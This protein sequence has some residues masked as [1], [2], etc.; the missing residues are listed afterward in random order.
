[1]HCEDRAE[2]NR[3]RQERC[4][5]SPDSEDHPD[6]I[7]SVDR[8]C[9]IELLPV[10]LL[11]RR[12]RGDL[13][14]EL[15]SG[16]V[17]PVHRALRN[18]HFKAPPLLFGKTKGSAPFRLSLHV[19]DVGH[20]LVDGLTGAGKSVLLALMALQFRRCPEAQIFAFDFGRS[21]RA[22]AIAMGG[23]WH[24]LGGALAGASSEFVVLR[25]LGR[26]RGL[27]CA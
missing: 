1:M 23:D 16:F 4:K 6:R 26:V 2:Q 13:M 17:A 11:L 20:T 8:V 18:R 9:R 15:V 3:R 22:A 10:V 7:R 21:I 19:R 14:D 24:D 27:T 5:A 12:R 25:R